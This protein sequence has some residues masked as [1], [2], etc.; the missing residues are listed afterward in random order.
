MTADTV[1][2]MGWSVVSQGGISRLS[3]KEIA[4]HAHTVAAGPSALVL[5]VAVCFFGHNLVCD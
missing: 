5:R 4:H 2:L 3:P 1:L